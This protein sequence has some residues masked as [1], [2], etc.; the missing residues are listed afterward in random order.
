[1]ASTFSALKIQLMTTGENLNTW[2]VVTNT[3][4]GTALEEAI[5]GSADVSFSSGD[6]TLTLSDS[7]ATQAARNMRLTLRVHQAVREI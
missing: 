3:N 2:G 7:N 1:M 6:V 4:L 5:A